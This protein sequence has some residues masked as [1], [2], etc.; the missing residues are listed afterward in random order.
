M[1]GGGIPLRPLLVAMW[2]LFSLLSPSTP[3]PIATVS[4]NTVPVSLQSLSSHSLHAD[5]HSTRVLT[6]TDT[7]DHVH[8]EVLYPLQS[9]TEV[10][11]E[12]DSVQ[13]Q[14]PFAGDSG[15][16]GDTE[17]EEEGGYLNN[18]NKDYLVGNE[19]PAEIAR[20]TLQREVFNS[21]LKK[22]MWFLK[23]LLFGPTETDRSSSSDPSSGGSLTGVIPTSLITPSQVF[24][25]GDN[26]HSGLYHTSALVAQAYHALFGGVDALLGKDTQL[27]DGLQRF[28]TTQ[29]ARFDKDVN[30]KI[31]DNDDVHMHNDH[32]QGPP[33]PQKSRPFFNYPPNGLNYYQTLNELDGHFLKLF[34]ALKYHIPAFNMPP[35]PDQ[36][37]REKEAE[38]KRRAKA[39]AVEAATT[40]TSG[41][42]D[43]NNNRAFSATSTYSSEDSV[44]G[45]VGSD[46]VGGV[47]WDFRQ[48]N[49]SPYIPAYTSRTVEVKQMDESRVKS[50]ELQKQLRRLAI[51]QRRGRRRRR[52]SDV[53]DEKGGE[54]EMDRRRW[55]P[56]VPEVFDA[57]EREEQ[58]FPSER[59][60]I[61][62]HLTEREQQEDKHAITRF[63][64]RDAKE[65]FAN[66]A[67]DADA[68]PTS[69]TGT[70]A[71]DNANENT[72]NNSGD[73][74]LNPQ[75]DLK[76]TEA[77]I[78]AVHSP[79]SPF[80]EETPSE[81]G[82]PSRVKVM[83][84]NPFRDNSNPIQDSAEQ[85]KSDDDEG[86]TWTIGRRKYK[87]PKL[88]PS[89]PL[90][91]TIPTIASYL[92]SFK[93]DKYIS[94]LTEREKSLLGKLPTK[95]GFSVDMLGNP[96]GDE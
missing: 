53:N 66:L 75:K 5:P 28:C 55:W 4:P 94:I 17:E 90:L 86:E 24:L 83:H 80:R 12:E 49:Y 71:T 1:S 68:T 18:K 20:A 29:E 70:K 79:D 37:R 32:F 25:Y 46:G 57:A 96:D 59:V 35:P 93:G 74:T 52:G 19:S 64:G 60:D 38:A 26:V 23:R 87:V 67:E 41:A 14:V 95:L 10:Y 91:S 31:N 84:D 76:T 27:I 43:V 21:F 73:S 72:A 9:Q 40:A 63:A 69:D 89:K 8:Q 51:L 92:P 85:I 54:H 65:I 16:V 30:G 22:G 13:S 62:E 77:A 42:A 39:A 58:M 45:I 82:V 88:T 44:R 61:R 81:R 78:E 50:I 11:T 47:G 36:Q 48:D 15:F 7:N 2:I 33:S 3:V 6:D 34:Q 56:T